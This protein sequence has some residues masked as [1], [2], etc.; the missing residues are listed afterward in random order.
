M[1]SDIKYMAELL[2]SGA[3][4]L[5]ESCPQCSSPLFKI[6][7]EIFCAKCKKA[8]VK[9]KPT[10]EESKLEYSN[11]VK[12]VEQTVLKKIQEIESL[13]KLEKELDKLEI[14]MNKLSDWLDTLEKINKIK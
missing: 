11:V 6:K 8:V 10:D 13:I 4:M 3:K 1:N 9:L 5:S 12:S 14:L 7:D 2:K